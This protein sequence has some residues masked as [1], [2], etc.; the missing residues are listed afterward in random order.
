MAFDD[1]DLLRV[2]RAELAFLDAGGYDKSVPKWRAGLMFEDSP[3]CLNHNDPARHRPCEECVLSHL[4][5]RDARFTAVP[6]RHI[7]LDANGTTLDQLYRSATYEETKQAVRE[8]LRN[9]I[10]QMEQSLE[11]R[12][13]H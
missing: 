13:H 12:S 8:W 7:S 11:V 6:C 4:V 5:P 10:A 9:T 1:R 2:L 3:S